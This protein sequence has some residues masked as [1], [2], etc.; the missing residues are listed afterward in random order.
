MLTLDQSQSSSSA[1]SCARPVLVPCPISERATRMTT[2]SSGRIT[3]QAVTS[4]EPSA[5]RM[6]FG[7][8]N[9]MSKPSASPPPAAAALTT[10]VRRFIFGMYVMAASSSRARRSGVDR[11]AHLL[12]GPAAADVGDV[13]V[14][15]G[16]ARF[17][18]LLEQRRNRH[19][20]AALA[21]AALR[22][23]MLEPGLLH[24]VQRAARG[25]SLDRGDLLALGRAHRQRAR[26]HRGSI[27]MNRAGAALGNAAA[28]FGAGEADL[29][30]QHP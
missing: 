25:K 17:R 14:N 5:A 21:I 19:D 11:R 24:L 16:V 15:V 29:F 27:D 7:P 3:T 30:P 13:G 20:H 26:A 4:G 10:K 8:P 6:I 12:I 1:T 9:G 22:N 28:V 18:L 23:V 2:L